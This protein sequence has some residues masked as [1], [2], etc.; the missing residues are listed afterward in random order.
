[1][2]P[3]AGSSGFRQILR[4]RRGI[5]LLT[6]VSH[7]LLFRRASSS[8]P[9]PFPPAASGDTRTAFT[10]PDLGVVGANN[11]VRVVQVGVVQM[12]IDT[13]FVASADKTATLGCCRGCALAISLWK[14]YR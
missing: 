2:E 4:I 13:S 8:S 1:M 7:L 12:Q 11:P 6:L 9:F 5:A 3:L 14:R 10:I